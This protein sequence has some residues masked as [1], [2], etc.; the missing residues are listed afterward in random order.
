MSFKARNG[1]DSGRRIPAE[2]GSEDLQIPRPAERAAAEHS[3]RTPRP[4][5][6]DDSRR[7]NETDSAVHQRAKAKDGIRRDADDVAALR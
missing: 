7:R 6:T 5:A 2:S 3:A 4:P 1:A